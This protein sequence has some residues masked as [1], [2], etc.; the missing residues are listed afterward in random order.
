ME[1]MRILRVLPVVMLLGFAGTPTN[2][3][4]PVKSSGDVLSFTKTPPHGTT[5]YYELNV[6]EL[7]KHNKWEKAKPLLDT[8]LVKYPEMSAFHELM[9]RYYVHVASNTMTARDS[10]AGRP[11]Y[12]KARYHL[13]RAVNIDEKNMKARQMMVQVETDTKHYSSAIVYINELLEENPYNENLWRKKIDLYR[14]V[15][16]NIEADRLLERLMSIYPRDEELRKDMAYRKEILAKNQRDHGDRLGQEQSLR[17]LIELEPNRTEHYMALTNLLYG[18]GRLT[19]AAEVAARGSATPGGFALIEKRA[20]ILCDM[21]RYQEAVEYVKQMQKQHPNPRMQTLLQYL[22]MEAARAAQVNDPYTAYAKVYES[23]HS[24]EA[25]DY[26]VSTSIQRNYYDDALNYLH[27]LKKSTGET[28]TLLYKEYLVNKRMG[29][30]LKA[31]NILERLYQVQPDNDDV[32]NEIALLRME[33]AAEYI[34]EQQYYEAIPLLEFVC[35]TQAEPEVLAA[36]HQRLFN[37]YLQTRQYGKA[38]NQLNIINARYPQE[39]G[40]VQKAALY[41]TWGRPKDAL[42]MLAEAY[43]SLEDSLTSQ[44]AAIAASYEEIAVPYIKKLIESGMTKV[45]DAQ[46]AEANDICSESSDLL[47]YSITTA[48]TLGE[49]DKLRAYISRGRTLFPDDPYYIVKEANFCTAEERYEEARELLRPLFEVYVADSM[50]VNAY[51]E[52]SDLLALRCLKRKD[53]DQAMMVVDSALVLCPGNMS[54]IYTKGLIYERMKDYE[55]AYLCFKQYKPGFDE[56]SSYKKHMEDLLHHR[57]RNSLNFEYQQARLGSQD[58]ITGEASLTYTRTAL[59]NEYTLGLTYAGRDGR[60]DKVEGNETDLTKG[61]IGL[62]LNGGWQHQFGR[63]LTGKANL[64]LANRYFPTVSATLSAEYELR[65]DWMLTARANYR[66]LNSYKGI[67]D[68]RAEF[69][70][71]DALGHELYGDP[72]YVRVG[73]EKS[74]KSMFQLGVGFMKPLG[75]FVLQA[76]ADGFLLTG[77]DLNVY[78]NGNVKMQYFPVEG[79]STHFFAV[80]GAGTA[81]ESS[82]IDRSMPVGF[83]DVN[84]FVGMGGNYFINSRISIGLSG[85]WYT[86]LSQQEGL[87]TSFIVNDPIVRTDYKNYFYIHAN[88]AISF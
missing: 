5:A 66:L 75:H 37:C 21:Y 18:M 11:F 12:D 40:I 70:G 20:G 72:E 17:Q 14:R 46:L 33:K 63:R 22:Q 42:N 39:H 28:A 61:G 54:L 43:Y 49:T 9:G 35:S 65:H 29:N 84:A 16:N 1:K 76:G 15:G 87:T 60:A 77:K 2:E 30:K 83:K 58:A 45:A 55:N 52:N 53:V 24:R 86:M 3:A 48:Q 41:S 13:I 74:R 69:K 36:A 6:R 82:L 73:W 57:Y 32:A 23:Q 79:R 62:Q 44:R 68:W 25:L 31:N 67:Y 51:A 59:K 34:V 19:E 80:C 56:L 88:V 47:H 10:S 85:T 81:P 27:E 4:V 78:V 26:L 64:A 7:F 71:Y 50:I 8:A 38:E